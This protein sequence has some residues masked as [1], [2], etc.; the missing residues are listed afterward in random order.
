MSASPP[1]PSTVVMSPV[2]SAAS[3]AVTS[4]VN[5]PLSAA[6]PPPSSA[7]S[8]PP[9]L[10]SALKQGVRFA[11]EEKDDGEKAVDGLLAWLEAVERDERVTA[12]G[13]EAAL[14][15]FFFSFL[16]G[17]VVDADNLFCL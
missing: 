14:V 15:R 4:P 5:A 9:P 1:T 10:K 7:L 6:S 8:P 17:S 12:A 11:E 16:C 2:S 3:T 13:L